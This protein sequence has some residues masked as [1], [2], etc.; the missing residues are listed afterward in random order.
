MCLFQK[1]VRWFI[2]RSVVSCLSQYAGFWLEKFLHKSADIDKLTSKVIC[3]QVP[4]QLSLYAA[5]TKVWCN[6]CVM[7]PSA[8]INYLTPLFAARS[9]NWISSIV[10][11]HF[12]KESKRYQSTVDMLYAYSHMRGLPS[13]K[14]FVKNTHKLA[15]RKSTAIC[16]LAISC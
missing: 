8:W 11:V 16:K 9:L 10:F 13:P 12:L 3:T 1:K 14:L 5:I 15:P 7:L 4:S 6:Y 2:H